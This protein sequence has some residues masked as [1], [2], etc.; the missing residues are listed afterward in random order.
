MGKLIE[1][2]KLCLNNIA[3]YGDSETNINNFNTSEKSYYNYVENMVGLYYEKYGNELVSKQFKCTTYLPSHAILSNLGEEE[4]YGK[5][6]G[7]N[8]PMIDKVLKSSEY[9]HIYKFGV[10]NHHITPEF[11]VPLIN[12]SSTKINTKL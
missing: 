5:I 11:V 6:I 8:K 2:A 1:L 10:T 7:N 3:F 9:N 4:D 12:V